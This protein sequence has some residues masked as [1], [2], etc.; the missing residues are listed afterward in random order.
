[1]SGQEVNENEERARSRLAKDLIAWTLKTIDGAEMFH[2]HAVT[3]PEDY[4]VEKLMELDRLKDERDT[5]SA[6]V[7]ELK[8]LVK[9]LGG[10]S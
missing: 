3:V 5:A 4:I 10:T 7:V 1:M 8:L 2:F 6:E 9:K